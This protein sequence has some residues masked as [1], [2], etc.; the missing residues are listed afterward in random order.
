VDF[1][2]E[3][4]FFLLPPPMALAILPTTFAALFAAVRTVLAIRPTTPVPF[5]FLAMTNSF[6]QTDCPGSQGRIAQTGNCKPHAGVPGQEKT[7]GM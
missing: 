6:L 1:L 2:T 3:A 5:L 7:T 4:V